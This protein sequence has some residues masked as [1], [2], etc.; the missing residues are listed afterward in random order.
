[1]RCNLLYRTSVGVTKYEYIIV[2]RVDNCLIQIACLH[3]FIYLLHII[4]A[5]LLYEYTLYW[6]VSEAVR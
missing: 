1:M 5:G 6:C 4:V 2:G 3:Q